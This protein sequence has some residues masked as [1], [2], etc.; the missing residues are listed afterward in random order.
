[1]KDSVRIS[2]KL[3]GLRQSINDFDDTGA[4]ED[5]DKLTT[6][7]R[8]AETE[9][10]AALVVEDVDQ[11]PARNGQDGEAAEL[12]G[13]VRKA[14]LGRMLTG[15]LDESQGAGADRELREAKGLPA[16]YIPW[17][18]LEHRAAVAITG[19]EEGN[20]QPWIQRVFPRSAMAFCGVDVVTASVGEELVPVITTGITI[21]DPGRA[22]AQAESSPAG[23]V[24][25]LT[26]RRFTGGFPIAR[27][28]MAK[29]AR[30]EEAFREEAQSAIQD[31]L[32]LD[33]LTKTNK[34]LLTTAADTEPTAPNAATSA[35]TFLSDVYG[36]VDG[37]FANDVNEVRLL[38]EPETYGYMGGLVYD[39][40]SGM[41]V[42]DKMRS[43]GVPVFA[44]DNA[45]AYASNRQEALVI[46]GP[47]RRNSIG[48]TWGGIEVIRDEFTSASSGLVN[49]VILTM[50]DFEVVRS[51]PYLRKRYRRS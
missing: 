46:Q 25:T 7:Y 11:G 42:A 38:V 22:T 28:D 41:T 29:F 4:A 15:I 51:G 30:I 12:R 44:T 6:E 21:G 43:I 50:W 33:F 23:S 14:S 5:L 3:S 32:D 10:R 16:S 37:R 9:Y 26:P 8:Q 40:G 13:L 48:A 1:M 34:G 24:T 17:E 47:P 45:G 49:F 27:E 31:A 35:A 39:T 36:A 19:D 20:M 18:L 2:L